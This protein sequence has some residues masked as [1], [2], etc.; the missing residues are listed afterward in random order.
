MYVLDFLRLLA[1]ASVVAFHFT[2]GNH[3]LGFNPVSYPAAI[4]AVTRYGFLGVQV[5]FFISG[6]VILNSASGGSGRRF[7]ISRMVRL[8]PAYWACV[9]TTFLVITLF[10]TRH[11]KLSDYA[12]N[13]TMLEGF[14]ARPL[15]DQVYW[16]LQVELLFYG[17]VWLTLVTG[18]LKRIT[19]V[20]WGWLGVAAMTTAVQV[21]GHVLPN[22]IVVATGYAPYF[23]VGAAAALYL[24]GDR[25]RSVVALLGVSSALSLM[26]AFFD[27]RSARAMYHSINV[28]VAVVI[29]AASLILVL[30]VVF[31]GFAR[32]GRPW[33]VTAGLL[34]YPLYLLHDELSNVLFT[35]AHA[36]NRWLLLPLVVAVVVAAS[37]AVHAGVETPLAPR[38]RRALAAG[39]SPRRAR[40]AGDGRTVTTPPFSSPPPAA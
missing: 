15:V 27:A 29:V 1:A 24:R 18:Q 35:R 6:I 8:Y 28:P 31:G 3:S 26:R 17:I 38:L 36:L 22:R 33:M 32:Y 21:A 11:I 23:V 39:S 25:K 7:A 4:T 37:W 19:L 2:Y 10:G 9:T 40:V 20:L 5:F 12:I 13:M 30:A 16:T 34:T 14:V